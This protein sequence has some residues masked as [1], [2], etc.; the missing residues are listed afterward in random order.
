MLV[1]AMGP[2]EEPERGLGKAIYEA[3][4]NGLLIYFHIK[5]HKLLYSIVSR[6]DPTLSPL[7]D[8]LLATAIVE[9]GS[10]FKITKPDPETPKGATLV[11]DDGNKVT[12]NHSV[13]I[14]WQ[15]RTIASSMRRRR[16]LRVL[17]IVVQNLMASAMKEAE[18]AKAKANP[19]GAN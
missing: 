1:P 19:H 8:H 12:Y 6:P 9:A 2:T 5:N 13:D 3:L 16:T 7:S 18:K 11:R 17:S 14:D 10:K 4:D 15:T